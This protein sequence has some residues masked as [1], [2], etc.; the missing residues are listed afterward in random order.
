[1]YVPVSD[2]TCLMVSRDNNLKLCNG[3]GVV[4]QHSTVCGK[5]VPYIYTYGHIT[6]VLLCVQDPFPFLVVS[7]MKVI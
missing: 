1:M 5:G 2:N 6:R 3:V 4:W 7:V